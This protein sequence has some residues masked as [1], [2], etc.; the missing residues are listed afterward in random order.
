MEPRLVKRLISLNKE[1]YQQFAKPFAETRGSPQ[2]GFSSLLEYLPDDCAD[3]LDIGCG[4][5]R[6]IRFLKNNVEDGNYTGVDFSSSMLDIARTST[7]GLFIEV[8]LSEP[9]CLEQLGSYDMISCLAT[10]QHVPGHQ[11]RA[12]LLKEISKH[13]RVGGRIFL[14][15]WQ[16]L[17]SPRQMKKIADWSEIGIKETDLESNDYLVTW[18]RGGFGRR[19]VA[20]ID[21]AETQFLAENAGL[22]IANSFRSD[23]KEGNLNLY[24]VLSLPE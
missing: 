15:N 3:M 20:Q 22:R 17:E 8:D 14:S 24:T 16:F 18:N 13:I 23:G 4:D 12:R 10:L 7:E 21:F 5:A 19:Y 1:F 9:D 6:F 2:P 11:N